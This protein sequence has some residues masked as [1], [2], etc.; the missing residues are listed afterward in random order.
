MRRLHPPTLAQWGCAHQWKT[1]TTRPDSGGVLRV[2]YLKCRHC[3]LRVK[4]EERLAV[5]WDAQNLMA[6]VKSLLPEGTPVY[7]R[8]RGIRELPLYG[9]NT[10]LARQ[11]YVIHAA[12]VRDPKRFVACTDKEGRVE[13]YGLFALR[14]IAPEAS[15]R[16]NGRRRKGR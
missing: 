15:G 5:P 14:P 10:L 4:S 7:L 16:T 9:L 2:R 3:G 6:L 1:T 12:K 11:G 13:Q 8:D